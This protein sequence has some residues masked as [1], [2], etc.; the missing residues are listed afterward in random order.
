MIPSDI[1]SLAVGWRSG[2]WWER[3]AA[4][5]WLNRD[6]WVIP[7]RNGTDVY[8]VRF[9]LS[10]AIRRQGS[11][12]GEVIESGDSLLLHYFARGDDDAALHDHPWDFRTTILA[13][14]YEEHLPP[15]EWQ[16][17]TIDDGPG[18]AWDKRRER[19]C[20]G[21]I[22]GHLSTDLHCVGDVSFGT[23]TLVRT[24]PRVRDWGF[25]PP[26]KP[27]IGYKAFLDERKAGAA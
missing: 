11:A 20:A 8:F 23:W 21:D 6:A 12:G 27:W 15:T 2:T 26:G 1:D 4:R 10:P 13:G 3:E 17:G 19:R 9:W 16:R 5:A 24:G 7:V 18:P 25:H 22:V 14:W